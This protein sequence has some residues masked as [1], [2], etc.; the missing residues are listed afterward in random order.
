MVLCGI[1]VEIYVVCSGYL[2][3]MKI[4][5]RLLDVR[6]LFADIEAEI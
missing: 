5:L 3:L 2:V 1:L 4:D 6:Y